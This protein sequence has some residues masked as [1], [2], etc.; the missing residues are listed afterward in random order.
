MIKLMD[1]LKESRFIDNGWGFAD[2]S[3]DDEKITY[4]LLCWYDVYA[5]VRDKETNDI[6]V[7]YTEAIDSDYFVASYEYVQDYDEDG[8]YISREFGDDSEITDD[9]ITLFAQHEI[10][11]DRVTTDVGDFINGMSSKDVLKMTPENKRAIYNDFL[12]LFKCHFDD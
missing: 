5:L 2:S 7:V 4:T 9:S 10:K 3:F 8:P 6:Y 11:K 12:D 1:I